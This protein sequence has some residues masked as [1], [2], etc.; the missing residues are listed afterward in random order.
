MNNKLKKKFSEIQRLKN[1][2]ML[3]SKKNLKIEIVCGAALAIILGA[4]YYFY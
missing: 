1:T 4:V 3:D 2:N